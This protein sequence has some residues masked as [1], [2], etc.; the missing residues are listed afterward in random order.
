ML[1]IENLR[2]DLGGQTILENINLGLAAGHSLALSGASGSGKTTLLRAIAG[3]AEP[4]EGRIE[5]RAA[6]PTSTKNRASCRGCAPTKTSAW[7]R[8]MPATNASAN[9]SPTSGWT[10]KTRAN[11]RTNSP[12]ACNN[13]SPS[14]A[15]SSPSPTCS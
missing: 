13:A 11:T 14:H 15:R 7:S 9:C 2:I 6:S 1:H 3:L 10:A 4:Q 5:N 8:P 12:A